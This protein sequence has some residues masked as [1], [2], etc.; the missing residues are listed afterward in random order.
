MAAKQ[1]MKIANEKASKNITMRGV[2]KATV[3]KYLLYFLKEIFV[4]INICLITIEKFFNDLFV[5]PL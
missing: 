3:S 1:R 5:F 4:S 2:P